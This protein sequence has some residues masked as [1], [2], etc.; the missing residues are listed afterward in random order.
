MKH[1]K[2]LPILAAL[3]MALTAPAQAACAAPGTA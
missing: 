1:L 3:L 2:T